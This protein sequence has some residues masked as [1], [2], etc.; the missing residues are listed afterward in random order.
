MKMNTLFFLQKLEPPTTL[1]L[2]LLI[3]ISVVKLETDANIK[4]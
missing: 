4:Y 2:L 1:S 3:L